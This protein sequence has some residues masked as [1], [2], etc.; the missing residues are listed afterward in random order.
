MFGDVLRNQ[1]NLVTLNC[2]DKS[3]EIATLSLARYAQARVVPEDG[4]QGTIRLV[5]RQV[6]MSKAVA[7]L[8]A[9]VRRNWDQLY[10]LQPER[11]GRPGDFAGDRGGRDFRDGPRERFRPD[12]AGPPDGLLSTNL[13]D[14]NALAGDTNALAWAQRRAE[15][16]EAM[17][18]RMQEVLSTLSPE[19]RKQ[20]EEMRQRFEGMAQLS[21]EER[22]ARFEAFGNNP[23]FRRMMEARSVSRLL[24]TTPEQRVARDRAR[25]EWRQRREQGPQR[26]PPR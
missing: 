23:E 15:R 20:A 26:G 3:L 18:Q 6:T 14:T 12:F 13:A 10:A 21:P 5:V 1:N 2:L 16:R 7:K 22:R 11:G 8:A 24:N 9:Q 19:E 4:T 25:E 17:Q